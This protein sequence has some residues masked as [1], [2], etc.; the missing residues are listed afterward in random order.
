MTQQI[1][2]DRAAALAKK[3]AKLQAKKEKAEA[4]LEFEVAS[5]CGL[6]IYYQ[7]NKPIQ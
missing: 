6:K 3:R 4:K 2:T 1:T 7:S 5:T